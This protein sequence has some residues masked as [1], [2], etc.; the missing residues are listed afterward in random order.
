M[1]TQSVIPAE[2]VTVGGMAIRLDPY[3]FEQLVGR[4][5]LAVIHGR[6]GYFTK[7]HVYLAVHDGMTFYSKVSKPLK[8]IRV[9]VESRIIESYVTL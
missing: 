7:W 6:I 3:I 8:L 5:D 1:K 9:S 2:K 4:E